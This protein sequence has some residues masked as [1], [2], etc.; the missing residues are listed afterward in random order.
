[1]ETPGT[2]V[3]VMIAPG[4]DS[5]EPLP[6]DVNQNIIG[7]ENSLTFNTMYDAGE[8]LRRLER[9]A[10]F[11]IYSTLYTYK[12]TPGANLRQEAVR[13]INAKYE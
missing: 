2:D 1:M 4:M 8:G 10:D 11:G 6:E 13:V 12:M 9:P 7:S 3:I 5:Q